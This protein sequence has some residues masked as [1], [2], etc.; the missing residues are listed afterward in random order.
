MNNITYYDHPLYV[1]ESLSLLEIFANNTQI[2]YNI[3]RLLRQDCDTDEYLKTLIDLKENSSFKSLSLF[4]HL[5]SNNL[6]VAYCLYCFLNAFEMEDENF[7]DKLIDKIYRVTN[8][9]VN[10]ISI[11]N[12]LEVISGDNTSFIDKMLNLNLT[13]DIKMNIL[14]ELY[15]PKASIDLIYNDIQK[16]IPILKELFAKYNNDDYKTYYTK[17]FIANLVSSN[18]TENTENFIV[19]PNIVSPTTISLNIHDE[20]EDK[21]IPSSL[22]IGILIDH[23]KLE[24]DNLSDNRLEEYLEHFVKVLNDTSKM[25]IVE[26]LKEKEMYG[27]Q[28]A[29]ALNLKTPTVTHHMVTLLNSGIVTATKENNRINYSYNKEKCLEIIEYLKT[30]FI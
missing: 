10:D 28:I 22:H 7:K 11:S 21:E 20:N 19:V 12:C 24:N 30:K 5:N 13:N 18:Y 23:I 1:S 14:K 15:N 29:Q 3:P 8:G 4:K 9:R 27:A 6:N 16:I 26:L 17:D 25:K 2:K